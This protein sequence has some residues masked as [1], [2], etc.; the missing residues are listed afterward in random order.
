MSDENNKAEQ[1]RVIVITGPSGVGKSTIVREVLD[2]TGADFS[3]SATTRPP[4]EGEVDYR[5]YHF[6]SRGNF[7]EMAAS[8]EILEWAEVYGELYGTPAF[9]VREAV[10]AGRK[11]ILEIDV[12]GGIQ[13]H[14]KL[15]D[16]TYI[17]IQ[18]PSPEVLARRLRSRGTEEEDKLQR[19]LA[20]AGAEAEAAAQSGIYTH[21]VVNDDLETA[22]R[23]VVRI[24]NMESGT[25]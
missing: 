4:R 9:P 23:E 25:K 20:E 5:E 7:E 6:I 14:E 21:K 12:Q 15:P 11:I 19:R 17:L 13:V 22:I 1:G 3:V 8:G 18:P 24:V 10:R 2:R 16:A